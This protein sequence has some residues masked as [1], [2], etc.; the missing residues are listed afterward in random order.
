MKTK[1]LILTLII[2]L[3]STNLILA[4]GMSLSRDEKIQEQKNVA[5]EYKIEKE[6]EETKRQINKFWFGIGTLILFNIFL[7]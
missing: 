2:V 5:L 3:L 4:E 7:K 1:I 6:R